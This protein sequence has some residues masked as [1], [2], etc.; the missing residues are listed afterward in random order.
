MNIYIKLKIT[1]FL[2]G[3]VLM[4]FELVGLRVLA[5]F[6]GSSSI[7]WTSV[8]GIILLFMSAGYWKGGKLAD[9]YHATRVLGLILLG[10]AASILVMNVSKNVVLVQLNSYSLPLITKSLL[11]CTLLFGAPSFLMAMVS[12]FAIRL[13]MDKKENSGSVAGGIYAFSTLGSIVGTFLGGFVLISFLG[14]NLIIYLLSILLFLLSL[15]FIVKEFH[16]IALVV[17]FLVVGNGLQL[18]KSRNY[19]DIDTQYARVF[20]EHGNYKNQETKFLL[21]D[22]YVNSGMAIAA[23]NK[24]LFEYTQFFDVLKYYHPQFDRVLL[25]GGGGFSYPKHFQE[26]FPSA[27]LDI[28]EIDGQLT[29]ISQEHFAFEKAMNTTIYNED[30]RYF[31]QK[32]HQAYDVVLY[33]VLTSPLSIPFHLTTQE[34]FKEVSHILMDD[35]VLILNLLGD[36]KGKSARFIESEFLT[37]QSVFPQ[38]LIYSAQEKNVN[39][40]HNYMMVAI[41]QKQEILN[42]H[43]PKTYQKLLAHPVTLKMEMNGFVLTDNFAPVDHLIGG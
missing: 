10:A 12:P 9:Q 8:I 3:F 13:S 15:L 34:T 31:L 6:L 17:A 25:F 43:I 29:Q 21:L 37:L 42:E 2:S 23:P 30:A 26:K 16:K 27:H 18:T 22:G 11:A 32:E 19:I 7:V 40:L 1:V 35:G 33:D 39:G 4:V 5:P 38:V 41:K 24:L 28:V 14:T 36:L 20:I